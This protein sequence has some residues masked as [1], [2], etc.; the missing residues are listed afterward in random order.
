MNDE[1]VN[2]AKSA[3][4]PSHPRAPYKRYLHDSK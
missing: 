1:Y 3:R 4:K 2:V